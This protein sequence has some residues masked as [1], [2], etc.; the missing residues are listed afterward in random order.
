MKLNYEVQLDVSGAIKD[1]FRSV[2]L[3]SLGETGE[4][5]Y[6]V[7]EVGVEPTSDCNVYTVTVTLDKVAGGAVEADDVAGAL[8]E[9]I[10]AEI[11]VTVDD[12]NH[13]T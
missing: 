6:D 3:T 2:D 8:L 12:V 9:G 1:H 5:E 11:P 13:V 10:D 4:S 7:R